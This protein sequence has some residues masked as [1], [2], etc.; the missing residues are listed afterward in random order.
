MKHIQWVLPVALSVA[1]CSPSPGSSDASTDAGLSV[2]R[3][4]AGVAD[5]GRLDGGNSDAGETDAG[6]LDGGPTDG[7]GDDAATRDAGVEDAGPPSPESCNG[8]DDDRNGLIDDAPDGG[9]L[10]RDCPLTL[11]VCRGSQSPCRNGQFQPCA[12]PPTY[13]RVETACDGVDNDCDGQV[14][15]SVTKTLFSW[16]AGRPLGLCDRAGP[17]PLCADDILGLQLLPTRGGYLFNS[18]SRVGFLDEELN[19]ISSARP[20]LFRTQQWPD[21]Q[22]PLRDFPRARVVPSGDHWFRVV[23][24]CV[25]CRGGATLTAY[26]LHADGGW[27]TDSLGGLA[28]IASYGHPLSSFNSGGVASV[29]NG[30]QVFGFEERSGEPLKRVLLTFRFDGGLEVV[31]QDAGFQIPIDWWDEFSLAWDGGFALWS[32]S[33]GLLRRFDGSLNPVPALPLPQ[34]ARLV[35]A[36]PPLFAVYS[37]DRWAVTD[38]D[39]VMAFSLDAGAFPFW[40]GSTWGTSPNDAVYMTLERPDG[41]WHLAAVRNGVHH[42]LGDSPAG[43]LSRTT[44]PGFPIPLDGGL[45]V[46][47]WFDAN[48]VDCD[49]C[50]VNDVRASFICVP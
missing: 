50:E 6:G 34:F 28:P 20:P 49:L 25:W 24:E 11:G 37:Q 1:A 43:P 8:Q 10:T 31:S 16:D 41:G 17:S 9:V 48:R 29:T 32:R 35:R 22:W 42:L 23:Y 26:P 12:Y 36:D 44:Y 45:H 14:D 4:D 27:P 13:Q 15:R 33:Q 2:P 38:V 19:V 18:G 7:G 21:P 40:S 46:L 39:G 5:A 30:L 3:F 47:V